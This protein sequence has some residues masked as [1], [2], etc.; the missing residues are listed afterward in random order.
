[1]K[2]KQKNR[3]QRERKKISRT[4]NRHTTSKTTTRDT[5]T[6]RKRSKTK[7]KTERIKEDLK[8]HKNINCHENTSNKPRRGEATIT[9]F[10]RKGKCGRRS[11]ELQ[12]REEEETWKRG[13]AGDENPANFKTRLSDLIYILTGHFNSSA[14]QT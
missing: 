3:K 6:P 8:E 5:S 9:H 4:E 14:V 1:M 10:T 12:S 13:R 2:E 11:D 7:R